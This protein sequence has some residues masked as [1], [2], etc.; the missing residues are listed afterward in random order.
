MNFADVL[1]SPRQ[2]LFQTAL[3]FAQGLYPPL[4]TLNKDLANQELANGTSI[5]S[6]LNGYQY[7]HI[8]GEA[9]N[10]PDTIW[11]K[12]DDD[13]PAWTKASKEYKKSEE[14]QQTMDDSRD[15]YSQFLP[16]LGD[17]MG[18]ENVSYA[19]AYDV[20][21]LL[22]TASLQNA[23]SA[24]QIPAADLDQARYLANE[25]EWSKWN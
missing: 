24:D 15:F 5:Q 10:A 2:V 18:P 3:N 11:L 21:D 6:P 22:N 19:Q 1:Y 13:C 16:L 14:Y 20:F 8:Q 12:G 25:W 7:I 4:G 23:S 9:E 17:I